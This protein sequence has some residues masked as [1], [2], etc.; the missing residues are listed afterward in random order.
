MQT[1]LNPY[2]GFNGNTKEAMEFYQMIF[3][4]KL[5][6]STFKDG[7][8][9]SEGAEGDK[10]MHAMIVTDAGLTLMASDTPPGMPYNPGNNISISLS[11]YNEQE[12]RGYWDK[13]SPSA[14]IVMPLEKAP[15]GDIFGMLTD[16]FGI[17]W[18]VNV[19]VGQ[20]S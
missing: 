7:G 3:G 18:M 10:I 13:L 17:Q 15:W 16:K 11:G 9:P 4:G 5:T 12:L 14:T 19:V 20:H 6:M 2:M 1:K 8:M